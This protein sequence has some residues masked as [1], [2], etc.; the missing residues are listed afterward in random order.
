VKGRTPPEED[1]RL[2]VLVVGDPTTQRRI[3]L[4]ELFELRERGQSRRSNA[5]IAIGFACAH[6]GGYNPPGATTD[7][8]L[9]LTRPTLD[10]EEARGRGDGPSHRITAAM[11]AT[12]SPNSGGCG[13]VCG[14]E[15]SFRC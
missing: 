8:P 3:S 7:S 2:Q 9:K 15:K 4:N 6:Y 10:C 14:Q 1:K 13:G 11:F 12:R 5:V